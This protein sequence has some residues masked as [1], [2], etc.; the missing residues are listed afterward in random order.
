[1]EFSSFNLSEIVKKFDLTVNLEE[2]LFGLIPE[3]TYSEDLQFVL[4]NYLP[5]AIDINTECSAN[6]GCTN[7]QR[8][9]RKSNYFSLWCGDDG[10]RLALFEIHR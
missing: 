7:I 1:M 2:N 5:L 8:T 6:V 10:N 9:R 4:D 3:V